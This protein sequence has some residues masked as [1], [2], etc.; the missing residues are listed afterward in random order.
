[1]PNILA[2]HQVGGEMVMHQISTVSNM[3]QRTFDTAPQ[4]LEPRNTPPRL[5]K[6]DVVV[7]VCVIG[8]GIQGLA[9]ACEL[10]RRGY[11]VAAIGSGCIGEGTTGHAAG[12]L[13][14]ETTIDLNVVAEELGKQRAQDLIKALTGVLECAHKELGLSGEDFQSGSSLYFAAK[15]RHL[16]A[17][18]SELQT[19]QEYGL[20]SSLWDG[21]EIKGWRGF[22]GGLEL[23]G[24]YSVHPVRLLNALAAVVTGKGGY[25]F[26]DSPVQ[27]KSWFH[28]GKKFIVRAGQHFI[29]CRHLVLAT[30]IKGLDF[31]EQDDLSKLIVPAVSHVLVTEPSPE[32]LKLSRETGVI[33]IWDSS[34][35]Y[36]YGRILSDGRL[37]VGGEE[38]PGV[39]ASSALPAS[40]PYIQRLYNWAQEH[41]IGKLPPISC[42]WRASLVIPADGLPLL[43]VHQIGDSLLISAITDGIPFGLLLGKVIARAIQSRGADI[44]QL[45]SYT[46][47]RV[48][49]ARLLSLLP[50]TG[51]VRALSLQAAFTFLRLW[52]ALM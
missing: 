12:I 1:M 38:T 42:A 18:R 41:Y 48:M 44:D 4:W 21:N 23:H 46:R 10:A 19:R 6:R 8:I 45:L 49:K 9:A 32:L 15:R 52:D 47:R 37:L 24:E 20:S 30:G 2:P 27:A 7:D 39:V 13:S 22:A 51:R 33:N 43:K 26:E 36:H 50:K 25:V 34:E 14:K 31:K 17:L 3:T 28:N 16:S 11:K 29:T 40:D 35:L 5:L